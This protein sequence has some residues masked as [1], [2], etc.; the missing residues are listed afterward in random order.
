VI[1]RPKRPLEL[2]RLEG[3]PGK[4][5]LPKPEN[6]VKDL[7]GV[8]DCPTWLDAAARAEWKRVIP[9]LD[10]MGLIGKVDRAALTGYCVAYA[11]FTEAEQ[12][13]NRKGLVM[14]V[15]TKAGA[16]YEMPR[17]EV[18][19]AKAYFAMAKALCAEYGMTASARG[20]MSIMG[21]EEKDDFDDLDREKVE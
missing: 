21:N 19:I 12:I 1:G 8:P 20:R 11:R 15:L 17:P 6:D 13:L 3:N 14:E 9:I 7:S 18:S 10:A 16:S 4:R 2:V 5:R